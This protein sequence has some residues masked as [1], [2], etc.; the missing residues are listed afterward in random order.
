MPEQTKH[1]PGPWS[2][3][4]TSYRTL[5][6]PDGVDILWYTNEDDGVH[7]EEPDAPLIAAAPDLLAAAKLTSLMF[8]RESVDRSTRLGDDEY[9][10]WAAL[11]KA[12]AKAE[13]RES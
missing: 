7:C 11:N 10:A 8:K 1:T 6:G 13:G 5:V 9:E 4:G 12:I 3:D 2:W